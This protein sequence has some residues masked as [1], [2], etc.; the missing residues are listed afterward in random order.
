MNWISVVE[1]IPIWHTRACYPVAFLC[2][3]LNAWPMGF[4][5][6][7]FLIDDAQ[8]HGVEVRAIDIVQSDWECTL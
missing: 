3:L 2:G 6:L 7:R 8:R 1:R 5:H 4:Y